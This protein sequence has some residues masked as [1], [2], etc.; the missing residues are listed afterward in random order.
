MK[1][2]ILRIH[3]KTLIVGI[4]VAKNTHWVRI[5]DHKGIDV[6]KP[7]KI[8]NNIKGIKSL[9]EKIKK[10]KE[11]NKK[12]K[13]IIGM[14]P[15]GHY[16]KALAWQIK[17]KSIGDELVIVNPHHVKKSKELDDNSPEKSD[18]KDAGIIGRL[19]RDGRFFDVYLP[20][21]EYAELRIIS[22]SREQLVN[23]RRNAKNAAIA[24]I[25]EYF[26]EYNK[27]YK[28]IFSEGSIEII[29]KYAIPEEIKKVGIEEIEKDLK[30]ATQG[31]DW[32]NRAQKI[33][34]AAKNTIGVKE[35]QRAAKIKI[36]MLIEEIEFITRQ[37]EKLE[38]EM[39]RLMKEIGLSEY[40]ES[41][42][43]IGPIIAATF[44]GEVGDIERFKS[45]KQIRKLAGLNLYEKSSGQQKGKTKITKRGRPLLRKIIYYAGESGKRH[46]TEMKKSMKN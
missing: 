14:E 1:Q 38:E 40:L 13:V 41:I 20:E 28:N 4:D 15:S 9:E 11:K 46:N 44:I 5:M 39:K 34:E 10:T 12:K 21:K 32:K 24:V 42:D 45:W 43:G 18:R 37:I 16:W 31:R 30:K 26:P 36:R 3:E 2:K 8:N 27:I 33:Y 29:K 22:R 23:K 19:I 6:I 25:D 7:F 17:L 35:G